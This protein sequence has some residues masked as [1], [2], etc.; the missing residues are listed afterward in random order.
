[1]AYYFLY[2]LPF[3][4]SST[5]YSSCDKVNDLANKDSSADRVSDCSAVI[6]SV[7]ERN[8]TVADF[9]AYMAKRSGGYVDKFTMLEQK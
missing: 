4:G 8:I 2:G 6:A 7:A 3:G 9:S 1:M 5:T